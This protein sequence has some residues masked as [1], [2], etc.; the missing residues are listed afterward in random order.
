M[1]TVRAPHRVSLFGGGADYIDFIE[2]VGSTSVVGLAVAKYS[3]VSII[4]NETHT[5]NKYRISY[6]QIEE[7]DDLFAIRHPIIREA[8]IYRRFSDRALHISTM[9]QIPA[10]TGLGTSSAFTVSLIK[11]LDIL[12]CISRPKIEIAREAVFVERELVQDMGGIQ[13]QYWSAFG[14]AGKLFWS[15]NSAYIEEA[16]YIFSCLMRTK[17]LLLNIGETRLSSTEAGLTI[18]QDEAALFSKRATLK[19]LAEVAFDAIKKA[20]DEQSL[21]RVLRSLLVETWLEKQ[22]M[23]K[24]TDKVRSLTSS[25][26]K[27]R[28]AFKLLGA[29][30]TGFVFVLCKD[31]EELGRVKRTAEQHR[32]KVLYVEQDYEGVKQVL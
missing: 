22:K 14:G 2:K 13:D 15:K 16:G 4:E 7:V 29:G 28:C 25:L 9:S 32:V 12:Q 6:S 24:L 3:Y 5:K 18:N 23:V 26:E 19:E 20:T 8:L 1:I 27:E 11:A 17:A 21:S 31:E 10:G 30:Q